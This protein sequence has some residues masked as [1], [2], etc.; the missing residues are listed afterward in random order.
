MVFYESWTHSASSDSQSVVMPDGCRD[1]LIVEH[2]HA[3]ST[4][5]ITDWDDRAWVAQVKK[6]QCISGFRLCPGLSVEG[7]D[8]A[9]LINDENEI[10]LFIEYLA[11]K[12]KESIA[13]VRE[14]TAPGASI[15]T[16]ANEAGVSI[17]TLQRQLKKLN[18]PKPEYWLRLSRAR[19]AACALPCPVPLAD[20]ALEY[21]YSDQ[22]HMTRDFTRWFGVTPAKLRQDTTLLAEVNQLGAGNWTGEH[23]SIR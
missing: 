13:L 20:I 7:H 18:L 1:I 4:I 6:G 12:N 9:G 15:K 8:L 2:A 23:I 17:R 16:V 21:G 3:K 5:R 14:L 11:F 10:S 22:S 19:L